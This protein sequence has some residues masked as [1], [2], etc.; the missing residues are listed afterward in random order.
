[1]PMRGAVPVTQ[2]WA[3][4]VVHKRPTK[5]SDARDPK[6][7]N[8]ALRSG[9]GVSVIKKFEGGTNKK[10][11]ATAINARKLEEETEPVTFERVATEVKHAIQKARLEKKWTQ[12]ELAKLINEPPKVVQEYE[13]GKAI[14]N[15]QILGKMEKVLG[16]KLRGK[17]K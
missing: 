5:A 4:V 16:V 6:A 15:Q 3:P 7:V 12:V 13:S 14:P 9:V 8:A 11:P 1:M 2:D 17:L 10:T